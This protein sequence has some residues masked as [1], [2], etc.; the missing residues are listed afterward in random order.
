M[1]QWTYYERGKVRLMALR[2]TENTTVAHLNDFC[3]GLV[4]ADDVKRE[5]KVYNEACRQWLT[6][7]YG[8]WIVDEPS[9]GLIPMRHER[10]MQHYELDQPDAPEPRGHD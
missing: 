5:F 8:D 10:F 2:W 1:K 6:F 9:T 7:E 4:V 3:D